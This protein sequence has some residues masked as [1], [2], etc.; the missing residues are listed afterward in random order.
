MFYF[1]QAIK[2]QAI[3]KQYSYNRKFPVKISPFDK[4]N[5]LPPTLTLSVF[6]GVRQNSLFIKMTMD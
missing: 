5:L 1:S 3:L 2:Y 4:F 6:S